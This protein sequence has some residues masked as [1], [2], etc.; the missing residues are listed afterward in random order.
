MM[1]YQMDDMLFSTIYTPIN[2]LKLVTYWF[3]I[4]PCCCNQIVMLQLLGIT[5]TTKSWV[6]QLMRESFAI[7]I[8]GTT[9]INTINF[10]ILKQWD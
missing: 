1:I 9:S 4:F 2:N 5:T 8:D 6:L 7:G 10:K 3:G